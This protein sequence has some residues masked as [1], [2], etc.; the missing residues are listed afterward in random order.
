MTNISAI[1]I[2]IFAASSCVIIIIFVHKAII[3]L[4]DLLTLSDIITV[5]TIHYGH[6]V[7]TTQ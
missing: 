6:I 4:N 7:H 2:H 1:S 3:K 5:S